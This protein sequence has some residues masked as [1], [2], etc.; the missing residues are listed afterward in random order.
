LAGVLSFAQTPRGHRGLN[1]GRLRRF[2]ASPLRLGPI[3]RGKSDVKKTMMLASAAM[4]GIALLT[5]PARA[6][7]TSQTVDLA[8]IYVQKLSAGYRASKVV[9]S[10]VL[11]DADETI[12]KI[13]DLLVRPDGKALFAVLSI[14][15]FLS[16][17]A[18]LVVVPYD[19]LKLIENKVVLPGGTKEMLKML[20][21]FKYATE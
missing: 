16:L 3:N 18:H 7:G 17:G 1:F 12:G 5:C 19:S 10:S 6:Q 20:P 8:K 9:G 21:E 15:G 14:G 11:N 4:I 2:N 13:D